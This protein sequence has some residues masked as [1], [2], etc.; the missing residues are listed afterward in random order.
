MSTKTLTEKSHTSTL[1]DKEK[2]EA[3]KRSEEYYNKGYKPGSLAAKAN[4]VRK[5]NEK[6]N[7]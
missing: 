5:Y 6:N 1:T 2:E 3:A 4:M 7:K